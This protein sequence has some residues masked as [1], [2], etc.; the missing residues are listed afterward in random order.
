MN[1]SRVRI[2]ILEL[3]NLSAKILFKNVPV[4]IMNSIRRIAIAEVP[5]LAIE[6]VFIFRN[7]SILNDDMLAHRLGLIPL[8]TPVGKYKYGNDVDKP[9]YVS[10]SLTAEAKDKFITV[11]S[12]DI[13]SSDKEV[14]PLYEDIE[15][16]KLAPGEGIDVEMWAVMGVG[17]DHAK[18]SPVTVNVVRG[19]PKIKI[20]KECGSNCKRCV[21]SCPK[22]IIKV[23]DGKLFIDNLYECTVC[24]LCEK[25]CPEYIKVDIDE[26][27][28]LLYIESVGQLSVTE[29][30]NESFNILLSKI[31]E[32][33]NKFNEVD[34]HGS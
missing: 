29:I 12:R 15:I 28:S 32:F 13:K 8:R 26:N 27:S 30:I 17:R 9:E 3:N 22:G 2:K 1:R 4:E 34:M 25:E 19:V 18:W 23:S 20:L 31:D 11:Y 5:T 33:I 14:Y 6:R 16:V 7:D 24:R 21:E 10:L